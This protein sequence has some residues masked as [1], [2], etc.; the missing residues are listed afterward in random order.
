MK[1]SLAMPKPTATSPVNTGTPSLCTIRVSLV[2]AGRS[3]STS[4]GPTE[5]ISV[6]WLFYDLP[7]HLEMM[8]YA[9]VHLVVC[10]HLKK[11][12]SW[13]ASADVGEPISGLTDAGVGMLGHH[14]DL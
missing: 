11:R 10:R 12:M 2:P 4:G 14:D 13:L 1:I 8:T 7:S 6:R 9:L 3:R 5:L